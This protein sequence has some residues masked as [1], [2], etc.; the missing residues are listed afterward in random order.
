MHQKL[1]WTMTKDLHSL[2]TS[3]GNQSA[4]AETNAQSENP[5]W[6]SVTIHLDMDKISHLFLDCSNGSFI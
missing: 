3:T 2:L 6:S 1:A 5:G 4:S